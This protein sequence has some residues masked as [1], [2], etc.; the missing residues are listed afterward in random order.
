MTIIEPRWNYEDEVDHHLARPES[1]HDP[2]CMQIWPPFF[3]EVGNGG[4]V[5]AHRRTCIAAPDRGPDRRIW[6]AVNR[7]SRRGVILTPA[8]L[9]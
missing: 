3:R 1:S 6:R 9:K 2:I 4:T 5:A 7:T 8:L